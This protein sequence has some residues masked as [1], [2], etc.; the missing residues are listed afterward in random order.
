M[1][2][3]SQLEL[4]KDF[5]A[6]AIEEDCKTLWEESGIYRYDPDAP[7]EIFSVDTPPPY[8]SSAPLHV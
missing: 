2:A 8:V 3:I 6:E 4:P 5:D 7:G 1:T